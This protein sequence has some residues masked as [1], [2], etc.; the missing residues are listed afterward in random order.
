MPGITKIKPVSLRVVQPGEVEKSGCYW[1]PLLSFAGDF[2][3]FA[4]KYQLDRE[5]IV[6][7]LHEPHT[8]RHR[9]VSE[10][11]EPVDVLFVGEA[12]GGEEDKNGLP[13]VGRS[14]NLIRGVIK[15]VMDKSLRYGFAN[16]IRCRPPANRDPSQREITCCSAELGREIAARK[17]KVIVPLGNFSLEYLTGR[18]GIV[19]V[20]G[21][22]MRSNRPELADTPV[23]A[24]LHPAYVL[25]ANHEFDRFVDAVEMA[26][27]VALGKVE[28]L[29]G[30]GEYYTVTEV[31]DVVALMAA[32]RKDKRLTA[33]DTETGSLSP[34]DDRFPK[35]LCFSFSNEEGVGCTVP[36]DHVDSPWSLSIPKPTIDDCEPL[37]G[38]PEVT[39]VKRQF[40]KSKA[41]LEKWRAHDVWEAKNNIHRMKQVPALIKAWEKDL[42]RRAI[43]RKKVVDALVGFFEDAEVPKC[44]Q[45]EKFDRQHIKA[46]LAADVAAC[47]IDTM[48]IHMLLDERRNTHGLDVLA[49]LYTGMGGYHLPLENYKD[50]HAECDPER[51]G[52]YANIPGAVL[53][54][55]AGQDADVTLRCANRMIADPMYA[56][57]PQLVALGT[58]FL[59]S[60]SK[61]LAGM[62]SAGAKT[63]PEVFKRLR[64]QYQKQLDDAKKKMLARPQ[65]RQF[66]ADAIAGGRHGKRKSEVFE[67]NPGSDK[68]VGSVLWD[69]YK[70][71]PTELTDFG[72][73][74][75]AARFARLQKEHPTMSFKDVVRNAIKAREWDFFST[76][77]DVLNGYKRMGN[78]F[79][80]DVLTYRECDKLIGTYFDP[81][82]NKA[83][84]HNIVRGYFSLHGTTTGRLSSY[85]PNLQNQPPEARHGY[86]SRFG[87]DGFLLAGDYSQIELK[88]ACCIYP[89][90]GM[91]RA[92]CHGED[93]H[94][95]TAV[96][97]SGLTAESYAKLPKDE[98]KKWR[99]RAKRV[100][101]GVIYGIG[102]LGVQTTLRKEDVFVTLE[103]A[104][105]YIERFRATHPQMMAA[106]GK[107]QRE[108]QR[109]GY[110]R[111]FMGRFRRV[112]E[113]FNTN[114]EIVARALRQVINFPVQSGASDTTLIAA[115]L[116]A[117]VLQAEGFKSVP[118]LLVHDSIVV[119][120]HRSEVAEVAKLMKHVMENVPSLTDQVLDGVDWSWLRVPLTAE[121]EAGHTWGSSVV[122][123]PDL[124]EQK[125]GR[126]GAKLWWEDEK[127]LVYRKP[128]N[129]A[130][131]TVLAD[132]TLRRAA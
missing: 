48:S 25:R 13:F 130:E 123:E 23:V 1:C 38:E 68:Q 3:R 61:L 99:T 122:F 42:Q 87:A 83:D 30:E 115:I 121:F 65:V 72:L 11:W 26:S 81:L 57:D 96:K 16:T 85:D 101:F 46:A 34:F 114:E 44:G 17:P 20:C 19:A 94:T 111:S 33:M 40:V 93:V 58:Q 35:L 76:K 50:E 54:P 91:I 89:D 62:E 6:A 22:M 92:Y 90:E 78:E 28:M 71:P 52:S 79:V 113:V 5:K 69:Y 131:L 66:T 98:Q 119:D 49:Y 77:A 110:V 88:F 74:T 67:F 127:K 120:C 73:T 53:F 21:K 31:D 15:E 106:M 9:N 64:V 82:L 80:E 105:G 27:N 118:S 14:G 108:A 47:D 116:I 86:V 102:A 103:E 12:P 104:D 97:I 8:V 117:R 112:P 70:L 18:R 132:E 36:F 45:N 7:A 2:D 125:E 55:Y 100:N 75:L 63:N 124:L 37:P 51:G 24:C 43:K 29:P 109:N 95:Q 10:P 126:A 128:V 32:L 129:I 59:P 4:P 60:V 41:G 56:D 84:K 107:L 39:K